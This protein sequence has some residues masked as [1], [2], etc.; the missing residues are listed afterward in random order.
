M[1][2]V[3]AT[4]QRLLITIAAGAWLVL[5]PAAAAPGASP[6]SPT[7]PPVS[8]LTVSDLTVTAPKRLEGPGVRSKIEDFVRAY[9]AASPLGSLARWKEK[10]CPA[11][12]G[13]S[14]EENAAVAARITA[15]AL[16]VGAP[17]AEAAPCRRTVE[18][19]FADRP[20]EVLDTIRA[21]APVLL[22]Y[23][24]A[25]QTRGLATF[26]GTIRAW[27]TTATRGQ[28]GLPWLDDTRHRQP[29]GDPNGNRLGGAPASEFASVVIIVDAG[30]V[31]AYDI[32][33]VADYIAM[34]AL[35]QVSTLAACQPLPTILGLFAA[36]CPAPRP[37]RLTST[38]VAYLR[39]LYTTN[40]RLRPDSQ[41]L[42]LVARMRR[43]LGR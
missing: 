28:D 25:A 39:A 14:P 42:E 38:D 15:L 27:Y 18:V 19:F 31:Q 41:Q 10:V 17:V 11:V 24:Y 36:D 43:S 2:K 20:Q 23:H 26:S 21:K 8:D 37:D 34:L 22:G 16:E 33:A 35:S 40:P 30:K 3:D 32:E 5:Q 6:A 4:R 12:Q 7:P 9:G 1:A 29:G 13:L